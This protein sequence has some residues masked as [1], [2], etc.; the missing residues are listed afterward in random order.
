MGSAGWPSD[1]FIQVLPVL[2]PVLRPLL[3]PR[4]RSRRCAA[5]FLL[6]KLSPPQVSVPGVHGSESGLSA[7]AFFPVTFSTVTA[8]TES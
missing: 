5:G 4:A 8:T 7:V 1:P 2:P 3:Q 6:P